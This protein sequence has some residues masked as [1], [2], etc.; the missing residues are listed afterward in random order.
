MG[1]YGL[2]LSIDRKDFLKSLNMKN[3]HKTINILIFVILVGL[4][5]PKS[6]SCLRPSLMFGKERSFYF[7]D[8]IRFKDSEQ[9]LQIYEKPEGTIDITI[10][11][12]QTKKETAVVTNS[13]FIYEEY[14]EIELRRLIL[15]TTF[16]EEDR[17]RRSISIDWWSKF[18]ESKRYLRHLHRPRKDDNSLKPAPTNRFE[19]VYNENK[20]CELY[21]DNAASSER[22][23]SIELSLYNNYEDYRDFTYT[24]LGA[25]YI[26]GMLHSGKV[27]ARPFISASLSDFDKRD[28]DRIYGKLQVSGDIVYAF[29]DDYRKFFY[30]NNPGFSEAGIEKISE[31][32]FC[33]FYIDKNGRV[34]ISLIAGGKGK[35]A[36]ENNKK[37]VTVTDEEMSK[38]K[39]TAFFKNHGTL[40]NCNPDYV[41]DIQNEMADLLNTY[42]G[43][44]YFPRKLL[45]TADLLKLNPID[46]IKPALYEYYHPEE[47]IYDITNGSKDYPVTKNN[48]EW[49]VEYLKH[50]KEVVVTYHKSYIIGE[51]GVGLSNDARLLEPKSGADVKAWENFLRGLWQIDSEEYKAEFGSFVFKR[52]LYANKSLKSKKHKTLSM[53]KDALDQEIERAFSQ[54]GS[55]WDMWRFISDVFGRWRDD[56]QIEIITF[57][58][59]KCPHCL[60]MPKMLSPAHRGQQ[61]EKEKIKSIIKSLRGA[62]RICFTGGEPFLYGYLKKGEEFKIALD[63]GD[64]VLSSDFLEILRYAKDM[65]IQEVVID[66]NGFALPADDEKARKFFER[67]PDNV[68]IELSLDDEHIGQLKSRYNREMRD[69]VRVC[70]LYAKKVRYNLRIKNRQF[71]F[72]TEEGAKELLDRCDYEGRVWKKYMA[73]RDFY[74]RTKSDSD[75]RVSRSKMQGNAVENFDIDKGYND[76]YWHMQIEKVA[77]NFFPANTFFFIGHNGKVFFDAH[78]GFMPNPPEIACLGDISQASF[79]GVMLDGMIGRFV[80]FKA[81]PY[82]RYLYLAKYFDFIG[83]QGLSD[84][85]LAYAQSTGREYEE[86]YSRLTGGVSFSDIIDAGHNFLLA[87]HFRIAVIDNLLFG[88]N[89]SWLNDIVSV[90][91]GTDTIWDLGSSWNS[92]YLYPNISKPIS[93]DLFDTQKHL[94]CAAVRNY[95]NKTPRLTESLED[96]SDIIIEILKAGKYIDGNHTPLFK[97]ARNGGFSFLFFRES[98]D[99]IK[100]QNDKESSDK[101]FEAVINP[102]ENQ[103]RYAIELHMEEHSIP[104]YR[105][106]SGK[107]SEYLGQES[108]PKRRWVAQQYL[109]IC[110]KRIERRWQTPNKPIIEGE[111][112][113]KAYFLYYIV[114]GV[115]GNPKYPRLDKDPLEGILEKIEG[116]ALQ[117]DKGINPN[118]LIEVNRGIV[119]T[120]WS[121]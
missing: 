117:Y 37:L 88:K 35:L 69:V 71:P 39:N 7:S 97:T 57:C 91:S 50:F 30:V 78:S 93:L 87:R 102:F 48:K 66:T 17:V 19:L 106:L 1:N 44:Y 23:D 45:Q 65:G 59:L 56:I 114:K 86:R 98:L 25:C 85:C 8:A 82:L 103:L 83:Y 27:P 119:D 68:I 34:Y 61:M 74:G 46:I 111:P 99:K 3:I 115:D 104:F 72:G 84:K 90:D 42:N 81:H 121:L 113:V 108:D 96:C 9:V 43:N 75:I 31:T 12:N 105:I 77:E 41:K 13:I 120:Q 29:S 67:L 70:E 118:E 33:H 32:E 80:D 15:D 22:S 36:V 95:I 16:F 100:I 4:L 94:I 89:L 40:I 28:T 26:L 60:A 112:D 5:N 24:D 38:I 49:C 21:I 11:D 47:Q 10:T 18:F 2:F 101:A 51:K 62:D 64:G 63:S 116:G 14:D 110:R 6:G 53:D 107:L 52:D 73:D 54:Y 20:F 55:G 58:N 92:A 79:S 109:D 76:N